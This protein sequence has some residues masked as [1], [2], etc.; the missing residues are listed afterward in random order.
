[1]MWHEW[2]FNH[3]YFIHSAT[4]NQTIILFTATIPRC[5]GCERPIFDRF[6]L[7]VLDLTWHATCLKCGECGSSLE[8]RCYARDGR[9]YCKDDFFKCYGTKCSGCGQG[10]PPTQVVRRAGEGVYHLHCFSCILCQR[11]LN[12]GDE[13]YLM[14]DRKLVC[15]A[16]YESAKAREAE[17]ANKRPRTTITAKQLETLKSAY[18]RSPKPS[19][20]IREQLSQETGLDMRVVQVWFQNRRAKEKR[21]KKDAGR[22]RWGAYFRALKGG[23]N[24]GSVP[25]PGGGA[26]GGAPGGR[27]LAERN[28][29][30]DDPSGEEDTDPDNSFDTD[31][32]SSELPGSDGGY[33]SS[34]GG[35]SMDEQGLAVPPLGPPTFLGAPP[36]AGLYP[37]S[38]VGIPNPIGPGGG[39]GGGGGV[40]GGGGGGGLLPRLLPYDAGVMPGTYSEFPPS[41]EAWATQTPFLNWAQ[42]Y[43]ILLRLFLGSTEEFFTYD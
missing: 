8:G 37:F 10:I 39:A 33:P 25:S 41:P 29:G 36:L 19:R 40:G 38:D 4:N 14:E 12:T 21:L 35:L 26:P 17:A 1:M 32:L 18:N 20:H 27:R 30:L 24:P 42:L 6:I 23:G 7:K 13:F 15:K 5:A 43:S 2:C 34:T 28:R 22:S 31:E 16:D 9:V 11:Q 3:V